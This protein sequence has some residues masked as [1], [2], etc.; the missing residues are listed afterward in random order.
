MKR[1][2]LFALATMLA[3]PACTTIHPERRTLTTWNWELLVDH[4]HKLDAPKDENDLSRPGTALID[5]VTVQPVAAVMMPVSW[6][7]DTFFLNP[8]DGWKSATLSTYNDREVRYDLPDS[9]ESAV[10]QYQY[11]PMLPPPIVSD[12][13]DAPRFLLRW[14]WNSTYFN[15]PPH[16][17]Q[18]WNDYWNENNEQS[19]R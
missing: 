12:L 13:L 17:Q 11:A 16:D 9:Q 3:L 6:S 15:A 2:A 8:I 10:K 7:I 4:N 5:W 19:A 18:A 1:F 14:L